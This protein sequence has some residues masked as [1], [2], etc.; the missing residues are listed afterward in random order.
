MS[1]IVPMVFPL[2]LAGRAWAGISTTF[3]YVFLQSKIGHFAGLSS[4]MDGDD[5]LVRFGSP[6]P[7]VRIDIERVGL[8]STSTGRALKYRT[9]A[10]A[11]VR[12]GTRTT[13]PSSIPMASS[14]M[15]GAA[16]PEL[17]AIAW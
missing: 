17:T 10:A 1:P 2:Y 9:T 6:P 16:V 8:Q 4:E 14:A 7:P 15:E 11:W 3:D 12:A 13:S 5:S